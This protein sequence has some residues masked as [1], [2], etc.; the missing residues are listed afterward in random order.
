MDENEI[1]YDFISKTDLYQ[2][3]RED[4]SNVTTLSDISNIL[5]IDID[6]TIS[7]ISLCTRA[8]K[9]GKLLI[10]A[11]YHFFIRSLEGCYISLSPIKKLFLIRQKFYYTNNKHVTY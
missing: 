8:Q 5:D 6:T 11:R 4:A 2:K 3:L 10:D 9:N 7:F 1:L